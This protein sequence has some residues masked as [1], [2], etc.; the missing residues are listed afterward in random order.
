[1]SAANGFWRVERLWPDA[2]VVC[3]ASGP[4]LT[5]SQVD[6]CRGK[7]RVAVVNNNWEKAPWADVLYGADAPNDDIP[8]KMPFSPRYLCQPCSTPA[9]IPTLALTPGGITVSLYF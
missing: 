1:M 9:S 4:S 2:T 8:M 6:Y 5:Q 7:A 3:I